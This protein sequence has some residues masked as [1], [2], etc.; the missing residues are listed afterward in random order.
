MEGVVILVDVQ[1]IYYTVRQGFATGFDYNAF[2]AEATAG[3]KVV[4]AIAYATE[5]GDEKQ[6]QFQNILRAIGFEV[7]LK[8]YVQRSDGSRK[9][10]WD[11][12]IAVDA[13]EFSHLADVVVMATGDGD[14]DVLVE[15]IRSLHKVD[16]EVFGVEEFT[17][18]SLIRAASKFRPINGSLLLGRH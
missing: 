2:W 16:V 18:F 11:V 8:P 7:K 17:A 10:D 9:G 1:N 4:K 14:F 3:R 15:R 5:R 6:R 13:M 12:G